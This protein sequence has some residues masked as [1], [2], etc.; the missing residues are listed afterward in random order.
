MRYRA[1]AVLLL[2]TALVGTPLLAQERGPAARPDPWFFRPLVYPLYNSDEGLMGYLS[3]A[4][5]KGGNRRPPANAKSISLDTK[6][7]TSGTRGAALTFDA[8]GYWRDW[9]LLWQAGSERLQRAPFYGA[10]NTSTQ[11]DSFTTRY[12]RYSLLRTT[13]LAAVQRRIAGPLRLHVAA[14][15]RHYH[16]R[17]LEDSTAFAKFLGPTTA[18]D[19]MP[20]SIVETR[21]GLL[22]DTR[23]AEATPSHGVFLEVMGDRAVSGATYTRWLLSAREFIPIGGYEQTVLGFRQTAELARGTLPIPVAYERLTTW[24]PEDGFG[25]AT[26]LRLFAP[27]RFVAPNRAVFSGDWRHKVLDA[28]FPTSPLRFWLLGFADAGRLWNEGESP[29][30]SNLHWDVGVGARIQFGKGTLFGLDLGRTSEAFG[31]ALSTSF[32]F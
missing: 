15:W 8:P 7:A 20:Q 5:R 11:S 26:S 24:Y 3:I 27:G 10:G 28:P 4:W 12:Y 13:L 32:A 31:F 25:G 2:A 21:V 22:F 19:T 17:P 23:D 14:Q 29:T 9:R 30:L 16:A 6:L 1:A 18:T